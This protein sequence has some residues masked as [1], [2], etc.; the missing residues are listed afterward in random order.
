MF[1]DTFRETGV[2]VLN[3]DKKILQYLSYR[4]NKLISL[5]KISCFW[6]NSF[7]F[8]FN[9]FIKLFKYIKLFSL[10]DFIKLLKNKFEY[11]LFCNIVSSNKQIFNLLSFIIEISLFNKLITSL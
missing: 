5:I 7:L 6:I 2:L 9:I 8:E 11:E 1:S 10:F 3:A 4:L